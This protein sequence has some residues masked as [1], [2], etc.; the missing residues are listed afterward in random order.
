MGGIA[1][2]IIAGIGG[3]ARLIS[4]NAP[5][6]VRQRPTLP[7]P[8]NRPSSPPRS[9][10]YQLKQGGVVPSAQ[11]LQGLRDALTLAP[12]D[13]RLGLY[14]CINCQVYYHGESVAE[15]RKTNYSRCVCGSSAIVPLK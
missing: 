13:P 12:L 9:P 4:G 2:T 14:Q 5:R 1:Y 8:H 6:S 7:L 10:P 11:A 15:L 3:I